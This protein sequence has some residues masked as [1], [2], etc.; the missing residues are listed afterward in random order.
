VSLLGTW[1]DHVESSSDL[2]SLLNL[3]WD[4]SC[5]SSEW[6]K[7]A[8]E[9]STRR[10]PSRKPCCLNC[11]LHV[12]TRLAVLTVDQPV[13]SSDSLMISSRGNFLAHLLH[14]NSDIGPTRQL[15]QEDMVN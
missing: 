15:V 10:Y 13:E 12:R 8:H 1:T 14:G 3:V 4:F 5:G 2:G 7:S 9:R 11:Q 6:N